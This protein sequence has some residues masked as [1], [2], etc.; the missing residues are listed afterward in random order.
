GPYRVT[1]MSESN[2]TDSPLFADFLRFL[3]SVKVIGDRPMP[4]GPDTLTEANCPLK[5]QEFREKYCS[6]L[7]TGKQESCKNESGSMKSACELSY[8]VDL[9]LIEKDLNKAKA[10]CHLSVEPCN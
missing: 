4:L 6:F 5:V 9:M 10:I 3:T 2:A 7:E 1:A 8:S